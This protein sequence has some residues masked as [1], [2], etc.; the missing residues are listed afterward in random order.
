[1]NLTRKLLN[2]EAFLGL[3][4]AG[5]GGL[6]TLAVGIPIIGYVLSPLIESHGEIWRDVGAVNSFKPGTTVQV[7]FQYPSQLSWAGPTKYAAAW[8]RRNGGDSFTAFAI[9]CTHLGCPVHWLAEPRIFLCPCH[10]SV[11]YGDGTVAGG[12]A[13]RPLHRY[14]TR[15]RN[16]RVE[17]KTEPLPLVT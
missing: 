8:L 3:F 17:I 15:V 1:M 13:P 11:F 6:A 7:N 10:G 9:Y 12:P 16:G 14:R 5:V 2:R 4:I